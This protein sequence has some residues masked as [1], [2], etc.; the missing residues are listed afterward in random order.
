MKN[1]EE[2]RPPSGKNFESTR[3]ISNSLELDGIHF[4]W[5]AVDNN[6][7]LVTVTSEQLGSR[8]EFA[9]GDAGDAAI[10]L[11]QE[12]LEEKDDEANAIRARKREREKRRKVL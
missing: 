4:S 2:S 6:P 7:S 5:W 3:I 8:C 12:L 11:A 1:D 10:K 9:H